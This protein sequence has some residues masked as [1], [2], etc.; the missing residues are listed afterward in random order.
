MA[1]GTAAKV[2]ALAKAY[3]RD[4]VFYD[5]SA[6]PLVRGTNPTLTEVTNW[7]DE[8]SALFDAALANEGFTVPVTVAD[9]PTAIKTLSLRV[10]ALVADL[11]A[12]TNSKG[13]LFTERVIEIGPMNVINKEINGWVKQNVVGLEALGVPRT[14][15]FGSSQSYSV[16]LGRQT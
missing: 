12:F 9:A 1:Y 15:D 6:S 7:L 5:P 14:V 8:V 13:R 3:S 11:C 16:P 4:G 10:C 2:A